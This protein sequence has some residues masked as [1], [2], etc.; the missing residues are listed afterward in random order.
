MAQRRIVELVDDLD[1]TIIEDGGTQTFSL[2]G[3]AYEIDLGSANVEKLRD[4]LAP[5]ITAG[6]RV[7]NTP[8]S[9]QR[10]GGG[11]DLDAIRA[12]A[13]SNGFTV[14]DRGRIAAGIIE[15]YNAR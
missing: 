9:R 13:R 12:W 3:T 5:F 10:S 2:N 11:R 15:A 1:D 6:R 7:R 4:A 8:S 14:S